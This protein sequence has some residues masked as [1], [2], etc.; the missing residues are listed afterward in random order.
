MTAGDFD[1]D[2]IPKLYTCLAEINHLSVA[3]L[4]PTI[5]VQQVGRPLETGGMTHNGR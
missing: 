2:S 3:M 5:T 1:A 4:S